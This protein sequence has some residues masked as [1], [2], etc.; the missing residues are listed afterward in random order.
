MPTGPAK[1][2]SI[3]FCCVATPAIFLTIDFGRGKM[4][5]GRGGSPE[6]PEDLGWQITPPLILR[7]NRDAILRHNQVKM[8][9]IDSLT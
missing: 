2:A 5:F 4:H 1:Q 8:D 3:L 9:E 6:V 7:G